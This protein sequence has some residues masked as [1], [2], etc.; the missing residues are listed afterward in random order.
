MAFMKFKSDL[1][2]AINRAV[3][4]TEEKL[5]SAEK[6]ELDAHFENLLQRADQTKAWTEKVLA[7]TEA[8]LQ[9]NPSELVELMSVRMEEYFY[10]K[11]EKKKRERLTNEESLGSVMVDAGNEFGPG[12]SYGTALIKCG[13]AQMRIGIAQKDFVSS[14][15][16]NFLQPLKNFLESDMKTLGKERKI[17]ETKRLDLDASKNRLKKAKSS[18]S[19]DQ[20]DAPVALTPSQEAEIAKAE[21]DLHACQVEF[22]R[23][24]EVTKLLL[25]GISGAHAHHL[26]CLN[27]FIDAQMN[28]Y[29]QCQQYMADLQKQ[30]GRSSSKGDEESYSIGG[31]GKI[32][33]ASG[34]GNNF[35]I[36]PPSSN[37]PDLSTISRKAK[38]LYD[39]GALDD[40]ELSLTADEI[41]QVYVMKNDN[42]W[43]IGERFGQRGKVPVTY[44]ELI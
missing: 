30:L 26:K 11:L 24:A 23:Q 39:Y 40:T 21:K 28:Y 13:Q 15:A 42:D 7:G 25:E 41:I 18:Q 9:P 27:E 43:M 5:G 10:D 20:N 36:H 4:Y 2:T 19:K 34:V 3:Q 1:G 29:A 14:A 17:L 37:S 38:V 22:D 6:T 31:V 44:L 12:T 35:S 32:R 8:V 33:A 16:S